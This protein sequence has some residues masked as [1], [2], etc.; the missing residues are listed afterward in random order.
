MVRV[1][2]P[3]RYAEPG[4][5]QLRREKTSVAAMYPSAIEITGVEWPRLNAINVARVALQAGDER[6]RIV[7][8]SVRTFGAQ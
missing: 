8:G 2:A 3:R 7:R 5:K 6:P 1:A 4:R